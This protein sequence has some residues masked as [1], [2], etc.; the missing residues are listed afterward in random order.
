[1]FVRQAGCSTLLHPC[2]PDAALTSPLD[3]V[4]VCAF[5]CTMCFFAFGTMTSEACLQS[6]GSITGIL[7][8]MVFRTCE[9]TPW[10]QGCQQS[11]SAAPTIVTC[12]IHRSRLQHPS[13]S[14]PRCFH[15]RDQV[16]GD[17]DSL[18]CCLRGQPAYHSLHGL[19]GDLAVILLI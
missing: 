10:N 6:T 11:W 1:V 2:M 16:T 17:S 13:I 12:S 7:C 18:R 9:L 4:S 15:L 8:T 19:A 14:W 3:F 5:L